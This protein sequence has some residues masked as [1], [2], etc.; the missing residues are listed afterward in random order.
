MNYKINYKIRT[1]CYL[2]SGRTNSGRTIRSGKHKESH[3]IKNPIITKSSAHDSRHNKE[4]NCRHTKSIKRRTVDPRFASTTKTRLMT[5]R[6]H[7]FYINNLRN[8]LSPYGFLNKK[9]NQL[10]PWIPDKD[11]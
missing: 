4:R 8:R 9:R 7:V 2:N 3:N 10:S 11:P 5:R 1:K 6:P